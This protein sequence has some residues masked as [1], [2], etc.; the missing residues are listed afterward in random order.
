AGTTVRAD[1][2]GG[3]DPSWSGGVASR[4]RVVSRHT[5][6]RPLG[7]HRP[8]ALRRPSS[9]RRLR[10]DGWGHGQ[11]GGGCR[12]GRVPARWYSRLHRTDAL[13]PDPERLHHLRQSGPPCPGRSGARGRRG[14]GPQ[15][16]CPQL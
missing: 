10:E 1:C 12:R 15:H 3:V 9:L 2:W 13:R 14:S 6:H 7:G 11:D 16:L 5:Q 4:G 8:L